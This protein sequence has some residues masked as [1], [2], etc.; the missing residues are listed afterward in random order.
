MNKILYA[1]DVKCTIFRCVF[2]IRLE[3]KIENKSR[4]GAFYFIQANKLKL[5]QVELFSFF[6]FMCAAANA[7]ELFCMVHLADNER[8]L[9]HSNLS[10]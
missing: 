8:F 7:S 5:A 3:R 4:E 2:R 9:Y 1:D 6:H 10:F